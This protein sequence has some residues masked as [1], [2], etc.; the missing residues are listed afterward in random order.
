LALIRPGGALPIVNLDEGGDATAFSAHRHVA[1]F[2]HRHDLVPF[3]FHNRSHGCKL[4]GKP[5]FLH[6]SHTFRNV[7]GK[8]FPC[9]NGGDGK[10]R[11]DHAAPLTWTFRNLAGAAP[12]PTCMTWP[13]SPFPQF[14]SPQ[15]RHSSGPQ[16][17]THERQNSGVIPV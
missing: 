8:G 17:A 14:G 5:T 2:D 9:A 6:N 4:V 1:S 13:G 10:L 12:W 11:E 7:S 3:A 15:S 16:M